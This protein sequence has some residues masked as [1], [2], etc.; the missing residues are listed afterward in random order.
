M[1]EEKEH[2]FMRERGG[3]DRER[4]ITQNPRE[5]ERG[6]ERERYPK[7]KQHVEWQPSLIPLAPS[8][9]QQQNCY[10]EERQS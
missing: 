3:G 10:S 1:E 8:S 6:R 9:H 5:R 4:E 2:A 7:S